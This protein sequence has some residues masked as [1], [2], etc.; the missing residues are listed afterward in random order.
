MSKFILSVICFMVVL[1]IMFLAGLLIGFVMGENKTTFKI[2]EKL[3]EK[4][5]ISTDNF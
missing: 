4:D 5:K 3:R 1:L 2:L